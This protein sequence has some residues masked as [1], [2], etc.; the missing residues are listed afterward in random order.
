MRIAYVCTDPGVPIFGNKGCS[1][2]VRAIIQTFL[3]QGHQVELF[4]NRQGGEPFPEFASLKIHQLP[5][6]AK[7]DLAQREDAALQSNEQLLLL[8]EQQERFDLVYERYSLWNFA[9]ME[10]A[11]KYNLPSILEVNAPLIEEQ[12]EH[13]GL[14]HLVKAEEVARRTFGKAKIIAAVS[15]A[16]AEYLNN[17]VEAQGK[18]YVV[19]NGVDPDRFDHRSKMLNPNFSPE[20]F[21]I[22][23]V[24]TMKPWHDLQTLVDAFAL[25]YEQEPQGRLLLIGDGPIKSQIEAQIKQRGCS[26]AVHFTGAVTSAEIPQLLASMDV[27]VAP[28][29]LAT[30]SYFSPL[31]VYEYMAAGLAVIASEVGQL[32]ELIDDGI[33]GLLCPQENSCVLAE[34]LQYLKANPELRLRLGQTARQQVIANHTWDAVVTKLLKLAGSNQQQETKLMEIGG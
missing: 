3:K 31:K 14:I 21:V 30:N 32:Q 16:V 25:F 34:K 12:K 15:Q 2:H 10:Y 28:Y 9:G 18:V 8:L 29:P 19:P 13:R 7:G 22:G 33:N 26:D 6:L 17:Y 1:I 11:Q 5:Q 23:F 4:T 27:A 20:D 24:G